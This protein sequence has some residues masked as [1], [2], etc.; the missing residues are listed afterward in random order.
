MQSIYPGVSS[1]LGARSK[2]GE[3]IESP[4]ENLSH[5]ELPIL[6]LREFVL[7]PYMV[8]PLFVARES[9]IAAVQDALAADRL[10]LLVAQRDPE[11]QNPGNEDL[12]SVGTVAM[13][14]RSLRMPDGR[15]KVMLQG[16]YKAK[17]DS[18]VDR[19]SSTWARVTNIPN[20]DI[21]DWSVES[22]A[23]VRAVRTRVEE[24]LP[25]KNLPP[26]VLSITT[27]IDKPGRL[28]DLV[29]SNLRLRL[30]EAQEVLEVRDPIARLRKVDALVRRELEVTTMQAEIQY[31]AK[32]EMS[33][34][35]RE[36]F[37]REQ[38]RTIQ[39]EL[40]EVDPRSEESDEYRAKVEEAGLPHSFNRSYSFQIHR[41][42]NKHTYEEGE[43]D[44]CDD[45]WNQEKT[46]KDDGNNGSFS[47]CS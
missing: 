11:T 39:D 14:M 33:R 23:L 6:P 2:R 43:C 44:A 7:Y 5:E 31:Q 8:I 28:A 18:F 25:L 24:L 15:L 41:W 35:Q 37:L 45:V 21:N 27:N 34:S 29:A 42:N 4:P 13:V 10:I 47:E 26:E 17:I 36:V 20:D 30:V 40:G 1:R 38:L 3:M 19:E 32:E 46:T 22:E 9:S 16:L 12:Y